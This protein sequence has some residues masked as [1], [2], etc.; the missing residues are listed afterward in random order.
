MQAEG[1]E[2]SDLSSAELFYG[3]AQA[4]EVVGR[5]HA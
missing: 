5:S 4:T 3:D 1:L 2:V